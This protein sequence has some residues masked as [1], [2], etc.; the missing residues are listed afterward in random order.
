M[1]KKNSSDYIRAKYRQIVLKF[2]IEKDREIIHLIEEQP[3]MTDFVRRLI[4]EVLHHGKET[5]QI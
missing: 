1:T 2:E 3:N 5:E 4:N